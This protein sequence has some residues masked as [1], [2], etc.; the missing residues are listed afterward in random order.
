M[1]KPV[2]VTISHTLSRQEAISRLR[3]R[4]GTARQMLGEY[5]IVVLRDEWTDNRLDF[6][7]GALGQKVQGLVEVLDD[8]FRI[9]LQLPWLLAAFA[10]RIA[11]L[12]QKRAPLLLGQDVDKPSKG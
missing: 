11:T 5:R 6:A 3:E 2:V 1:P 9:E 7:V 4:I 12:V 8:H 10:E